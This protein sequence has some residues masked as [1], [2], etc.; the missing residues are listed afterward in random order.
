[1]IR[2]SAI[3]EEFYKNQYSISQRLAMLN[4]LALGARE[5]ASM[6]LPSSEPR[7][8]VVGWTNFPSKM[9][10]P[11]LHRKYIVGQ[12]QTHAV[13]GLLD[14][15][16]RAAIEKGKDASADRVPEFTRE[17]RLRI[18]PTTKVNEVQAPH[19]NM[20]RS[21]L[22]VAADQKVKFTDVA[23]EFFIAPLI[24]RFWLF[25]RD[26][27]TREER[28]A[29]REVLYRYRGAG[30]G[31]ILN[32]MVLQHFLGTLAVLVHASQNAPEWLAVIAPDALELAVTMGTKPMSRGEIDSDEDETSDIPTRKPGDNEASVLATAL[33]LAIVVLDGSLELDGGRSLGL[34]HT[35][36]L[37]GPGE[38]AGHVFSRVEKGVLIEGG[39]G[40]L[41]VRLKRAAAGLVLKVDQVT[42]RWRRAMVD[43]R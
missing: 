18:R 32:P 24:N 21:S 20:P 8:E 6:T 4:A 35:A 28:T 15:I 9:L 33:E 23:A 22:T 34:D 10:P 39:G 25:L 42:S 27:Q 13:H 19:A 3:I 30:T 36:L 11:H 31:L 7:A 37:L 5:L 26:E 12:E 41:A 43:M 17:R 38:W 2:C 40:T 16:S 1:L 14:G 29:Q